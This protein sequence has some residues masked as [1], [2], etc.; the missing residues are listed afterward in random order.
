MDGR[1]KENKIIGRIKRIECVLFYSFYFDERAAYD[2]HYSP[3]W[4]IDFRTATVFMRQ[5]Y[6]RLN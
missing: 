1:K 3:K 2:E 4:P 5:Q 6:F